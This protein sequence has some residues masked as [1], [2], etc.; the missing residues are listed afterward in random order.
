MKLKAFGS[1][2]LAT[3]ILSV[4]AVA[5]PHHGNGKGKMKKQGTTTMTRSD[6]FDQ[7]DLNHDGVLTRAEF[8]SGRGSRM[9]Q[10]DT[11]ND[12]YI[13]RSEWRGDATSFDRLDTNRDGRLNQS[14]LRAGREMRRDRNENMRFRGV[15]KNGDGMISRQEWP[16][17]D[18]SFRNHDRN[19]DGVLSGD[20][21]R[22]AAQ[23]DHDRD[24]D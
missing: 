5:A 8:E 23:R 14:E 16:G 17:N 10:M 3:A 19:N 13:S 1:A 4:P 22:P 15:D 24:D 20:E 7:L 9:P 18:T 21:V 12:G 6:R 2:L 11:N